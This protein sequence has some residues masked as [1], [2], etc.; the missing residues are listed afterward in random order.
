M[1]D[2]AQSE[3]FFMN[4]LHSGHLYAFNIIAKC[5]ANVLTNKNEPD[6]CRH[7]T[8]AAEL[9]LGTQEVQLKFGGPSSIRTI[10]YDYSSF[11]TL[12]GI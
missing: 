9:Q 6:T 3:L 11:R 12:V 5:T 2:L 4:I 7:L 1:V 8:I 10:F